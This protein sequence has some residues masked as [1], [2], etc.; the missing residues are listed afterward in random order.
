MRK[1]ALTPLQRELVFDIDMTDYDPVRLC[2]AKADICTRCWAFISAAVKVLHRALQEEFGFKHL[3]WV[4]SGRRGI[5]CWISDKDA[6][7]LTDGQRKAIVGFLTVIPGSAKGKISVRLGSR[8]LPP[9]LQCVYL[10]YHYVSFALMNCMKRCARHPE[11]PLH[12]PHHQRSRPVHPQT[13]LGIPPRTY[14]FLI[15][16]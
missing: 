6:M 9:S 12:V 10:T 14:P 2:C 4:Y 1:T 3:M 15:R 13:R 11:R 16:Q 7:E 5:H 8:A